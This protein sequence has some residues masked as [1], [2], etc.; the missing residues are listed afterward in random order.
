MTDKTDPPPVLATVPTA[1]DE[2][3]AGFAPLARFWDEMAANAVAIAKTRRA[4][5]KAYVAE[6]FTEMQALELCKGSLT[7]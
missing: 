3:A 1:K 6:G 7:L 5:Y 4:L 2:M